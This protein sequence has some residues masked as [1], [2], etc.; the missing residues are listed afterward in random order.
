MEYY[1]SIKNSDIMK[2]TGKWINLKMIIL[3]EVTQI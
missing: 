1:L 2:F 3:S